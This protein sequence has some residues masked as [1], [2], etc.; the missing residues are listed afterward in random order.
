[1]DEQWQYG[2]CPEVDRRRQRGKRYLP[3]AKRDTKQ[4]ILDGAL[5]YATP[6]GFTYNIAQS[7]RWGLEVAAV[8][9]RELIDR[10]QEFSPDTE[11][12]VQ[13]D[14][15]SFPSPTWV[16]ITAVA[17]LFEEEKDFQLVISPW[18]PEEHRKPV[19]DHAAEE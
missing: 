2:H 19:G 12:Q 10:L 5:A 16:G 8:K 15:R 17:G 4:S 9:V 13:F 14:S 7:L 11:V 1:M 6:M 3:G 18:E